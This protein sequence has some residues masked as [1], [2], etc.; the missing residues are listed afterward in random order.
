MR[1]VRTISL[2]LEDLKNMVITIGFVGENEH[3]RVLIDGKRVFDEYPTAIPSLSIMPPKGSAYPKVTTRDGD[4]IIWDISDSDLVYDGFGKIQLTF[5]VDTV[6]VK[7]YIGRT[8]ILESI[9]ANGT[10]SSPIDDW[11]TEANTILAGVPQIIADDL[12]AAKE[13][14]EF[15]GPKGDPGPPGKDADPTELIDDTAGAGVL[16]RVWSADKQV[17]EFDLKAPKASPVFTGSISL[18][19]KANTTVGSDSYAVGDRVEASGAVSHAEGTEV[20][21]SGHASHAEGGGTRAI[22]RYSHAEGSGAKAQGEASHAE[23]SSSRASG[24]ASHAEGNNVLASGANSHAEGGQTTASNLNAHAEGVST[25]ASAHGAHAE[26]GGSVASGSVA[27]AEGSGTLASGNCA[28]AEGASST[29]SGDVS[30]AE[31]ANTVASG[32]VSHA[33][34]YGTIAK[35]AYQHAAGQYN[36]DDPSNA[37]ASQRGTYVEIIGNGTAANAKSNARTLD[38]S[39]NERLK[40]TLYVNCN[41]DSSGG[42]AVATLDANGKV[43]SSQLPSY[44]DDVQEYSSLSAFPLTG[45]SGIIYIALDTNK[46]YRWSGSVYVEIGGPFAVA[47]TTETQA[48]IDE[49][50][51]SA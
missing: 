17:T 29:A 27:H 36:V 47:T 38:W 4:I 21:A 5:T 41:A 49:Y 35:T 28:H 19:R 2:R 39:G 34:G 13:S 12:R 10:A 9:L 14:G 7:S 22:E 44:V 42:N 25:T 20:I 33:Q 1:L 37:E 50:G 6:V 31:G 32:T 11:I 16:D 8:R 26:G 24:T 51:V 43:P 15:D 23:G 48:I 40:G 30:H 46:T 18:G 3:T 45:E